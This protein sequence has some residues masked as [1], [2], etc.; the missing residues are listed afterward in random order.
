MMKLLKS[1]VPLLGL[2]FLAWLAFV[3]NI[4]IGYGDANSYISP[5]AFFESNPHPLH[6]AE[7]E[8]G[9]VDFADYLDFA[10][11]LEGIS[12]DKTIETNLDTTG[13]GTNELV[14]SEIKVNAN[15]CSVIN[16]I[17]KDAQIIWIEEIDLNKRDLEIYF[18]KERMNGIDIQKAL[19]YLGNTFSRFIETTES[20]AKS[21]VY[22]A[23]LHST[24]RQEVSTEIKAL[25][26]YRGC[27]V[28]KRNPA[29]SAVFVWN[30][31]TSRFSQL[32]E[33]NSEV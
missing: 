3:D 13:D 29:E 16:S 15:G 2:I 32:I 5:D 14:R 6:Q 31:E 9:L 11:R 17:E 12:Y 20:F 1:A 22:D 8:Q 28:F 10:S 26:N 33:F 19:A 7:E 25:Q 4:P 30:E 27:F 24:A 23:L 21:G 18:G